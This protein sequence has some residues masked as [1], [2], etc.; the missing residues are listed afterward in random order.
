MGPSWACSTWA[1]IVWLGLFGEPLEVRPG[2][3]S[4]SV[5]GF[6]EPILY[7]GISF[8][9]LMLGEEFGPAST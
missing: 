1:T 6:L 9:A 5:A 2:S 4:G 8:W 3:V 7:D